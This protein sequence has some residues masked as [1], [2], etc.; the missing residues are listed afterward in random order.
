[1]KLQLATALAALAFAGLALL[2][3]DRPAALTGALLAGATGVG[4]TVAMGR[5]ARTAR[6]PTQGV[7]LV[8]VIFFLVRL[9]LV[10]AATAVVARAGWNVI[11]FVVA[12]FVP[13][14]VL[15]ALEAALLHSLR[16]TVTPA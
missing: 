4:S 14:F 1:V 13:Y 5:A 8:F 15:S 16:R 12:F 10:G 2:A 3:P 9:A 7:L 6:K 11:A